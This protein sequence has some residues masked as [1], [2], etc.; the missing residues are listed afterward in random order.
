MKGHALPLS[1]LA[2]SSTVARRSIELIVLF[3]REPTAEGEKVVA[4]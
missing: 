3:K 2:Q 1:F 4:A